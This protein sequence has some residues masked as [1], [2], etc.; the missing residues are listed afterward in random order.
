MS[1]SSPRAGVGLAL[2]FFP[3]PTSI[4]WS[5]EKR[6][7]KGFYGRILRHSSGRSIHHS[8]SEFICQNPV[9]QGKKKKG[10][11]GKKI[12]VGKHKTV[13]YGPEKQGRMISRNQKLRNF[14]KLKSNG[15][16]I[17][18]YKWRKEA[19]ADKKLKEKHKKF[20]QEKNTTKIKL[21]PEIL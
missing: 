17:G 12:E 13:S 16:W 19:R 14:S 3:F 15:D 11:R 6:K 2:L 20:M 8:Y 18:G 4:Q 7:H 5:G 21:I 1:E 10:G 9:T